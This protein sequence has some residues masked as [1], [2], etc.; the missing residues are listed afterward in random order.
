MGFQTPPER[1][2]KHTYLDVLNGYNLAKLESALS[3]IFN[4]DDAV[5]KLRPAALPN[6]AGLKQ[7]AA[8]VRI[9]LIKDSLNTA[10]KLIQGLEKDAREAAGI[11][12]NPLERGK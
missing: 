1:L 12:D 10:A 5:G 6:N 7:T 3:S 8:M 4:A 2:L 11:P 9:K